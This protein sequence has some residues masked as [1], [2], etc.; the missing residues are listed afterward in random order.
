MK[1]AARYPSD[2]TDD[3]WNLLGPLIPPPKPGGRPRTV[4]MRAVCDGI[5]YVLRAG[6]QWRMLPADFPPRQTVYDYYWKW[7]Q[8]GTWERLNDTLRRQV[9]ARAGRHPE[10]SAGAIDSQSVKTTERGAVAATTRPR[11]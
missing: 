5:F 4:D 1:R 3:Q 8:D 7:Q 9:R 6:C 11:T 10:P 2:L